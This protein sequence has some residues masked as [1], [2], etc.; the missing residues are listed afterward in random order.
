[1]NHLDYIPSMGF[2]V[3]WISRINKNYGRHGDSYH[4]YWVTDISKLDDRFGTADDLKTLSKAR[5]ER[6]TLL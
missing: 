2:T 1:M 6:K 4:G 3:S 5:H